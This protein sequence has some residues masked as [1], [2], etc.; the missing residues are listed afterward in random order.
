MAHR[1]PRNPTVFL[2]PQGC[3]WLQQIQPSIAPQSVQEVLE[4]HWP[5]LLGYDSYT[6]RT[7]VPRGIKVPPDALHIPRLE[8]IAAFPASSVLVFHSRP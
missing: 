2:I 6:S 4:L 5:C 8:D 1:G 3:L 7:E